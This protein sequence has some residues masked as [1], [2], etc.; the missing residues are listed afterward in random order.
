MK[1]PISTADQEARLEAI[2]S[3][4]ESLD[5]FLE[6]QSRNLPDLL[7]PILDCRI[8]A[9]HLCPQCGAALIRRKRKTDGMFSGAVRRIPIARL[10]CPM[11]RANQGRP[12][13][14]L[15]FPPICAHPA[16]GRL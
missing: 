1:D 13:P 6:E 4:R 11:T 5:G 10:F 16:A 14:N 2:A 8:K 3:G 15:N 7:A 12:G 9:N